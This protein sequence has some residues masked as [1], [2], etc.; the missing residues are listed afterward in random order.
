MEEGYLIPLITFPVTMILLSDLA[1]HTDPP[2]CSGHRVGHAYVA[3]SHQITRL[4]L[5]PPKSLLYAKFVVYRSTALVLFPPR[6]DLGAG[7]YQRL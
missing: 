7:L 2:E 5:I 1:D 6:D 3:L 4:H